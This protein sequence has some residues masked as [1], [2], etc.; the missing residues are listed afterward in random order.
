[1]GYGVDDGLMNTIELYVR[2]L[3]VDGVDVLWSDDLL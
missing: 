2:L 3:G 1:M